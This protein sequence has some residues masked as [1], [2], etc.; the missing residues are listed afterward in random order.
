MFRTE[1]I[2]GADTLLETVQTL[3]SQGQLPH[4]TLLLGAEGNEKLRIAYVIARMLVCEGEKRGAICGVCQACVKSAS[5]NHPDI[6]FS[7]PFVKQGEGLAQ[8]DDYILEWK[9]AF[10]ANPFFSV[11]DWVKIQGDDKKQPNINANECLQIVRKLQMRP[12][13]ASCKVLILWMPEYLDKEGNRLLKVMEEPPPNTYLILVG[14]STERILVTILSRCQLFKVPPLSREEA[15]ANL[16]KYFGKEENQAGT[17]S[18]IAEGNMVEALALLDADSI[19]K[20]ELFV[21]WLRVCFKHDLKSV[22]AWVDQFALFN[23][24]EQKYILRFGIHFLKEILK[25][26]WN[27]GAQQISLP[28]AF[29]EVAS[30]LAPTLS[31]EGIVTLTKMLENEIFYI[32]RNCHIKM[33]L[34]Y[35]SGEIHRVF[36]KSRLMAIS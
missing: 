21:E 34:I 14:Q 8:A 15:T 17:A 3:I 30:K 11:Y 24:E 28:A 1:D 26:K 27:F 5:V 33:Q 31:L 20:N 2:Q 12:F 13:E 36:G 22:L 23:K 32:E 25:I 4:A 9:K 19:E 16:V 35:T 29:I 10:Q 6:M 18:L 7:F